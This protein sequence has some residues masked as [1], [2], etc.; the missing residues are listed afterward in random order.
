MKARILLM[1]LTTAAC[2]HPTPGAPVALD[3]VTTSVDATTTTSVAP[4]PVTTQPPAPPPP[5]RMTTTTTKPPPP[6]KPPD[7]IALSAQDRRDAKSVLGTTLETF[8]PEAYWTRF[9]L[10]SPPCVRIAYQLSPGLDDVRNGYIAEVVIPDPL[11]VGGTVTYVF[12]SNA[13]PTT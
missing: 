9:C 5:V 7:R 6:P 4:P 13:E 12:K 1:L 11:L 2:A 3:N 10:E 8:D